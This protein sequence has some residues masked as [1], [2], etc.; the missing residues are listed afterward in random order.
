MTPKERAWAIGLLALA[1]E[2]AKRDGKDAIAD[3]FDQR[4]AR[5]VE[6]EGPD[7][8]EGSE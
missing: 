5:L 7:S 6:G 1:R 3:W 8:P 4:I 2:T